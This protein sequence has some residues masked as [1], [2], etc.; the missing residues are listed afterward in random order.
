MTSRLAAVAAFALIAT[1]V[2][3]G[4]RPKTDSAE[5]APATAAVA[6]PPVVAPAVV[7]TPTPAAA[8]SAE[9]AL[10]GAPVYAAIYP[11]GELDG[12][13]TSAS[14]SA[15]DGGMVT[16]TTEAKPDAVIAFYRERAEDAGL[17]STAGMNQGDARAYGASG[18]GA[19]GASL[20]VVASPTE[21]G[22]TSVQLS[23]S[24][25]G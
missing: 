3:S 22:E 7:A 20:Q 13:P 25:G 19:A 18:P 2:V 23:W 4:C 24:E 21:A 10:P 12:A 5:P 15:G 9:P 1:V 8:P 14:G 6:A 17:A 11:G 16:Y